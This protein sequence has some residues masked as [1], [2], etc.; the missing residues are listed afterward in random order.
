[1]FLYSSLI[2]KAVFSLASYELQVGTIDIQLNRCIL[3]R[4]WVMQGE[5]MLPTC[6]DVSVSPP[7]LF[8]VSAGEPAVSCHTQHLWLW[9]SRWRHR[10]LQLSGV[11]CFVFATVVLDKDYYH[12]LYLFYGKFP[13]TQ[14]HLIFWHD[15]ST[16]I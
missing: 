15:V 16:I 10:S 14:K 7:D 3:N 12:C 4:W 9:K 13:R 2:A 1:M 5:L 11:L 6:S 8:F